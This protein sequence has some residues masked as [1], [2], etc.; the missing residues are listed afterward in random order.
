MS[1]LGRE[2][3]LNDVCSKLLFMLRRTFRHLKYSIESPFNSDLSE[4][5]E[6]KPIIAQSVQMSDIRRDEKS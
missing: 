3:V 6:R 5:A 4:H 1:T 2:Y